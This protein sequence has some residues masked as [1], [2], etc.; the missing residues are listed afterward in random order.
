M[1]FERIPRRRFLK[2]VAIAGGAGALTARGWSRVLG[3]NE[4][5]RVASIG[6]GGK[7]WSDHTSVAASPHV[8]I[9]ASATSTR[10][11][12]H[13]G[14]AA[15]KYP[16]ARR[17]T[18]WRRLLDRP[19]DFDAVIVSTPDHMHAPIAW[20]PSARQARLLPEA[21]DPH[22]LRGPADAPGGRE[23]GR[24]HPD[25]QPDP[26]A[27]GL[28]HG[29]E[30]GPRR[31]D[32]QGEGGPLLAE[33]PDALDAR[34]TIAPPAPTRSPE[35]VHWDEWLG[36]GPVRPYKNEIYHPF[37]WRA[38]QDFSNGQRKASPKRL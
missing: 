32:R 6:V 19:G 25:G 20:P 30:A 2:S 21:A 7:G 4:R 9:V 37:N 8:E 31:R 24:G 14:K 29:R 13:L 35:T 27:L 22:R 28:S 38:W 17:Y 1:S 10:G 11:R 23:G 12:T 5:L 34:R 15:E 36:V 18:D 3:A 26:V 33:R 16:H